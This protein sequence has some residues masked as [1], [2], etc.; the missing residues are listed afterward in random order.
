MNKKAVSLFVCFLAIVL[1]YFG[2]G[3]F[4]KYKYVSH[5]KAY[6]EYIFTAAELAKKIIVETDKLK[7]KSSIIKHNHETTNYKN[8]EEATNYNMIV[9]QQ[10]L[11]NNWQVDDMKKYSKVIL[12]SCMREASICLNKMRDYNDCYPYDHQSFENALKILK[13]II[14]Q[15]EDGSFTKDFY[16]SSIENIQ[17]VNDCLS[18]TDINIG[19][20]SKDIQ[21]RVNIMA[22][23]IIKKSYHSRTGT[24]D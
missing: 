19:E 22:E 10:I 23:D 13:P 7:T 21:E 17:Q 1:L 5:A 15:Y 6:K 18:A 8:K 2:Y 20:I 4:K 24:K 11:D 9:M 3:E 12:D 14:R 16:N